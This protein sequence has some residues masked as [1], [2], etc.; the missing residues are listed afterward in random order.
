V[1]FVT[2]GTFN[3]DDLIYQVDKFIE[4]GVITDKV[5]CQIGNGQYQPKNCESFAY[6]KKIG[7]YIDDA[8]MVICHG[9]TGSVLDLI[10]REK[11]FIAV[12][13]R[14]LANDHQMEFLSELSQEV[15]IPW[16]SDMEKLCDIY[17]NISSYSY[18]SRDGFLRSDLVDDLKK[19]LL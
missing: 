19:V 15:D 16:A 9:G 2:V 10:K 1:I 17:I 8:E 3:F 7:S 5:I 6:T 14:A 13:N 18:S 11:K 4:Q 12:A